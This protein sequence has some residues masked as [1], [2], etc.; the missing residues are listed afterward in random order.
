MME[1]E[2]E[3]EIKYAQHQQQVDLPAEAQPAPLTSSQ[4]NGLF[5]VTAPYWLNGLHNKDGIELANEIN[6]VIFGSKLAEG[7][8]DIE[9]LLSTYDQAKKLA[10]SVV[11]QHRHLDDPH[12]KMN[13]AE[14]RHLL[15]GIFV[16]DKEGAYRPKDGGR[17]V[18]LDKG[19]SLVIKNKDSKSYEAAV[20]LAK[21]K[22]WTAIS[23]KGKPAMM[24]SAWIAAKLAGIEVINYEPTKEA[25]AKFAERLAQQQTGAEIL[26]ETT[27]QCVSS[28]SYSGKILAIEGGQVVQKVGRDPDKIARHDISKLSRL[29]EIWAVE[30]IAYDKAG[31]GIVKERAQELSR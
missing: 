20:A 3:V 17:A 25:K 23:L 6:K 26:N 14:P 31:R 5:A 11:P 16:R 15:D 12:R 30:D 28:G 4:D 7:K 18:L 8:D 22:G 19:D 29:P 13:L 2:D 9:E 1:L 10:L 21:A 27:S 24:E